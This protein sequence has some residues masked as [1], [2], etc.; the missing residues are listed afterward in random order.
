MSSCTWTAEG[1]INSLPTITRK[2]KHSY[3]TLHLEV[4]G[5]EIVA[6]AH[7]EAT[8]D[9]VRKL[10]PQDSVRLTG[11]IEPRDPE[12]ASTRP[13]FL[14]VVYFELLQNS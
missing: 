2:G 14:N 4:K 8:V 5:G 11:I 10:K 3:A 9:A 13:Y 6:F 1:K 7:D 12:V